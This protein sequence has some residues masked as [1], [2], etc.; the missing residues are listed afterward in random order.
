MK[1]QNPISIIIFTSLVLFSCSNT[2]ENKT[3]PGAPEKHSVIRFYFAPSLTKPLLN[4][5][6]DE[7]IHFLGKET[8]LHIEPVIPRDHET[9]IHDFGSGK[10]HIGMMNTLSFIAAVNKYD[11][12]AR[13]KSVKY[14]ETSYRGQIIANADKNVNTIED[15]AGK[16]FA[17]T[18][19]NSTSGYLYPA[20]ILKAKGVKPGEILYGKEHDSVVEMVYNGTADAGATYYSE[21]GPNGQI[22]D[23][24]ALLL[25]K[26][27][28]IQEKVKIIDLTEPIPN[29]PLVFSNELP[30]DLVS[31]ICQAMIKFSKTAEGKKLLT[32]LYGTEGFVKC[33]NEDYQAMFE[34]IEKE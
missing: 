16:R 20:K 2:T 29:D 12:N 5:K 15:I 33:T 6:A 32:A 13:L 25:H 18:N 27:P 24:R 31:Q 10:A 3:V 19:R 34:A 14:G 22:R 30:E 7:L 4:D 11:V 1:S 26:Y 8:N 17:F 9:M 28:D 23:A 21:P